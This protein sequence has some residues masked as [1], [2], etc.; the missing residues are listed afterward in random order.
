MRTILYNV[1][2]K[3]DYLPSETGI[4]VKQTNFES[5]HRHNAVAEI[6]TTLEILKE[7]LA[8]KKGK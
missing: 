1:A 8:E 4:Y 3:F 2:F 5:I 6:R 7:Q